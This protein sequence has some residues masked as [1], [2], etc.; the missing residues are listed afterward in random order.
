MCVLFSLQNEVP[1]LL[2]AK[3]GRFIASSRKKIWAS[4]TELHVIT[5]QKTLKFTGDELME[6]LLTAGK[7]ISFTYIQEY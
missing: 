4:S 7:L 6:L 5:E 3:G 1:L 2:E